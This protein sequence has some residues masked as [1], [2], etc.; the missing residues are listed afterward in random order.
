MKQVGAVAWR[1]IVEYR[2]YV[3]AALAALLVAVVVP[4]IPGL[5]GW[6][7]DEVRGVLAGVMALCFTVL[8]AL[9]IGAS[10]V[11]A[12]VANGRFGFFM[13]RPASGSAVWFGKLL[14]VLAVIVTCELIVVLPSWLSTD[15]PEF[16]SDLAHHPWIWLGVLVGGPLV[17]TLLAHAVGTIWRAHTAWIALDVGALVVVAVVGWLAL[18]PLWVAGAEHWVF[19]LV[20]ALISSFAVSVL[21]AGTV[22]VAVGRNDLRRHHRALSLTM[23]PL[24]L[25]LFAGIAGYGRW[26]VSPG[27]D[28]LTWVSGPTNE[29]PSG[30]WITVSGLTRGRKDI[31]ADFALNL[32]TREAVRFGIGPRWRGTVMAFSGD[33]QRAAW[34]VRAR[35]G[36]RLRTGTMESLSRGGVGTSVVVD[37]QP[38]MVLSHRGDRLAVI[39]DRNLVV[40]SLPNG[41]LLGAVRLPVT[42][43]FIGPHFA[44]DDRVMVVAADQRPLD[45]EPA[46]VRV[47]EF[48]IAKRMLIDMGVLPAAGNVT[49]VVVDDDRNRLLLG[50]WFE[51]VTRWRYLD[52]RTIEDV[53]W[54]RGIDLGPVVSLLADGH[55]VRVVGEKWNRRLEVFSPIGVVVGGVD[56]PPGSERVLIGVQPSP[57]TLVIA[58]VRESQSNSWPTAWKSSL[59]DLETWEIREIGDGYAPSN[60]WSQY[61]GIARPAPGGCPTARL[62]WG[63][64]AS[65]NLW[66]PVDGD[67]EELIE[68]RD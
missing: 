18:Q 57:T 37:R 64:G 36:W 51:G 3:V 47:L 52:G 11:G 42:E 38:W 4:L 19:I 30:R 40:S 61:G 56:L 2:L 9:S 48:D 34:T 59:V 63:K 60:L 10:T 5:F 50:T 8:C 23:W 29:D 15:G 53:S 65:L 41:D 1:E 22:Q 7:P 55:V 35:D 32:E 66:D 31:F 12:A 39:E 14:G 13:A 6:H 46:S 21:V 44:S 16:L 28:D 20:L 27:I 62:F 68:G 24:L 54:T 26:L 33:G 45:E 49:S 25:V 43:R 58:A 67:F 17:L